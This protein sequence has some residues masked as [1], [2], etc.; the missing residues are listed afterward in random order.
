MPADSASAAAAVATSDVVVVAEPP[1]ARPSYG[2]I[3]KSS[4][5]I[6]G[7]SMVNIAI[8]IVRTK[9]MALLL[10]PAGVGL[11]GM[12]QSTVDL[13]V[14]VAGMGINSSGVRQIAES[15]G[16]GKQER[17]A[18]T[19]AVLRRTVWVLSAIGALLMVAFSGEIAAVTFGS[20][21]HAIAIALLS[22]ALVFRLFTDAEAA[23]IQGLRRIAD[24]AR[25]NIFGAL[26]GTAMSITFVFL[27]GVEGI[28]PAIVAVAAATTVAA[29]WYGR[30]V[31]LE[32]P[33]MTARQ[34][35]REATAL[36]RLGVAFMVSGLLMMGSAY[37]VRAMILH[38]SGIDAAGLYQASWTLGGLYV[39]IILQA[40]GA[41][42]Y[43]RLTGV[44]GDNRECNRLVNEQAKVSLL[45]AG[46]GVIAT[47]T[48][49]PL[50]VTLFYSAKFAESVEILRWICL[51]MAM[52]VVSWPMGFIILAKNAQRF[53][54]A[55]EVAWTV[56]HLSLAWV[57]IEHFGARGAGMAFFGSYVFHA[58]ITYVLVRLLS[59]F[60]FSAENKRYGLVILALIAVAFA[61][62]SFL[63]HWWATGLGLVALLASA[64]F[65][66]RA[67]TVL[68]DEATMPP[69]LR[70]IV[71]LLR[72]L[73]LAA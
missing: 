72:S 18:E 50:V 14:S 44:A 20:R 55:S 48:L 8:G 29:W 30:K 45:L 67:L 66:I 49:A 17:I 37:A 42:F 5:M 57:C 73:G 40:M 9:A 60:R 68:F 36:L 31:K 22:L 24:L 61:G 23:L 27:L 46:P 62:F 19:S 70:R 43:P 7:A 3:I 15:A 41:D 32:P 33:S 71:G 38:Q 69:Y 25:M 26:A 47:I 6:G 56:V 58:L 1:A 16:S 12:F 35:R 54:L 63:P 21:E 52:R 11:M 59:G 34:V 28:V 10:G 64:A 53:F 2:Q 13:A 4:V 39:G 65:T 51:G